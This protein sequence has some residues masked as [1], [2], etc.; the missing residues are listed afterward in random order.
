MRRGIAFIFVEALMKEEPKKRVARG[1]QAA[2]MRIKN[3]IAAVHVAD[4]PE[5]L[6]DVNR[7]LHH[8]LLT[9]V[10]RYPHMNAEVTVLEDHGDKLKIS[11]GGLLGWC[12]KRE[13]EENSNG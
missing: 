12:L 2:G 8:V 6:D 11:V 10:R 13:L 9:R 7:Y 5:Q 3:P 1:Y 4:S